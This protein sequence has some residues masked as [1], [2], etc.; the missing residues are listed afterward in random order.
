MHLLLA[1]YLGAGDA[2]LR[3]NP[4]L[5]ILHS[6]G[7]TDNKREAKPRVSPAGMKARGP[8]GETGRASWQAAGT[9]VSFTLKYEVTA[10][11]TPCGTIL[12]GSFQ[13][14]VGED[15]GWGQQLGDPS[16]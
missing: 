10:P 2:V 16:N 15:V 1:R 6:S 9:T 4:D 11:K 7:E 14:C 3:L 12:K 13:C 5:T 8:S